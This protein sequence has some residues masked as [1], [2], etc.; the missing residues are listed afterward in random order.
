[1]SAGAPGSLLRRPRRL[2]YD[3]GQRVRC[4]A[5]V[6]S[7]LSDGLWEQ[8]TS[9]GSS[10]TSY[11]TGERPI[12]EGEEDKP[13]IVLIDGRVKVTCNEWDEIEVLLPI[14]GAG[15]IV[16]QRAAIDQGVRSASVIALRPCTTRIRSVEEF[17]A[18][19]D[20][21]DLAFPLL[22]LAV[23]RQ[24]E[25]QLIRVKLTTLAVSQHL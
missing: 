25:G 11:D 24:R 16:G 12:G 4:D 7:L 14:R 10:R 23:A 22:R 19:V 1:M 17:F 21:Q 18:F 2:L 13:V 9:L 5:G 6:R 3:F 8:L 15:D 20:A